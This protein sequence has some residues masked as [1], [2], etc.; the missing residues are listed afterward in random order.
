M[1]LK[2]WFCKKRAFR[3]SVAGSSQSYLKTLHKFLNKD[4]HLG[5]KSF[6]N[7]NKYYHIGRVNSSQMT[8][9]VK[10]LGREEGGRI[11]T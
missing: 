10:T 7:L 3:N 2:M 6:F 4:I 9:S 11:S 1:M 8:V 5:E